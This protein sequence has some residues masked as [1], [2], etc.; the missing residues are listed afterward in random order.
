MYNAFCSQIP[1]GNSGCFYL[2]RICRS[3]Q[4]YGGMVEVSSSWYYTTAG[5][6]IGRVVF[7][8]LNKVEVVLSIT[9]LVSMLNSKLMYFKWQFS[10]FLLPFLIVIVQSLWLL[11]ALDARAEM[12]IQGRF[13][14]PSNLHIYYVITEI[15]KVVSLVLFGI[16][17]FKLKNSLYINITK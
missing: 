1:R 15:V 2:D 16:K 5:L 14:R 12:H 4:F 13:V 11:P 6:G 17:L 10:F 7:G 3:H 9:I 8:A